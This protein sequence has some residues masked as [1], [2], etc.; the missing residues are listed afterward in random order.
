MSDIAK[1]TTCYI[2]SVPKLLNPRNEERNRVVQGKLGLA[3]QPSIP[4]ATDSKGCDE[5]TYLGQ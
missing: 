1:K 4:A 3:Y 5:H 2:L